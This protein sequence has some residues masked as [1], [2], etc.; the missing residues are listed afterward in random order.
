M[1]TILSSTVTAQRD[2]A[3]NKYLRLV[4]QGSGFLK[5]QVRLMVGAAVAV[6]VGELEQNHIVAALKVD[7]IDSNSE[8]LSARANLVRSFEAPAVGLTLEKIHIE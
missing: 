7:D 8:S 3:G 5:H 6:G 2:S 1:R 4:F